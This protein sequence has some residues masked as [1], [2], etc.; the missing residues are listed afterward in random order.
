MLRKHAP[1]L[2][3]E[4]D[5]YPNYEGRS[6]ASAREI[7]TVLMNAAQAPGARCLTPRA[8][9]EELEALCR[10]KSVYE[11]LQTEVMDGYHDHEEFV[12]VAEA[13]YLDALDEEIRDS[14]GL[15]AEGQYREL[16]ARHVALV[17]H[18]VQ[19]EKVRDRVTG[20]FAPPD[21]ERMVELERI[22]MPPGE[23]RAAFRRGLIS[24][25]GAFRLDHPDVAE[26]DYPA[27]FP[28]LFRRLRDHYFDERKRQLHRATEDVLRYLS[29]GRSSLDERARRQVEGTLA[30]HADAVR[31][32]RALRAGRDPVPH[33][34]PLRRRARVEKRASASPA[35]LAHLSGLSP[36]QGIPPG[37]RSVRTVRAP[38]PTTL[39]PGKRRPGRRPPDPRPPRSSASRRPARATRAPRRSRRSSRA[40]CGSSSPAAARCSGAP[41]GSPS[42]TTRSAPTSSPT[43]TWSS[44]ARAGRSRSSCGCSRPTGPRPRPG[45]S[46]RAGGCPRRTS[47]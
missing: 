28:D 38:T 11:F 6:G 31:L 37:A 16:F 42:R 24:A 22:L 9:L 4:S 43:P 2:Y 14:M 15:V 44:P 5:V 45:R 12:R 1:D 21:E 41:P 36:R 30:D 33:A 7:K 34:P 25:V 17:S 35:R 13:E 3:R 47:R 29:D 18:W 26:I 40:P 27:I 19:G 32:L 8:V 39:R 20:A 46:S 23:D 10:D